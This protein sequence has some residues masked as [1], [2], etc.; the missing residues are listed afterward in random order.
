MPIYGYGVLG[1]P[2]ELETNM[3]IKTLSKLISIFKKELE[4][5]SK[6]DP[7]FRKTIQLNILMDEVY[8][9]KYDYS[10]SNINEYQYMQSLETLVNNANIA[11]KNSFKNYK[12][13]IMGNWTIGKIIIMKKK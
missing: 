3:N 10:R 1:A 9:A 8:I 12:F 7:I 2:W 11:L 6:Q 5:I 4:S 13:D